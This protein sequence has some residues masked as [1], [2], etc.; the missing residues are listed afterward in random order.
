M[1]PARNRLALNFVPGR[2]R[3]Q[4]P[5]EALLDRLPAEFLEKRVH[6]CPVHH[7]GYGPDRAGRIGLHV[8]LMT[9]CGDL[10]L[11]GSD[12]ETAFLVDPMTIVML[13]HLVSLVRGPPVSM[14]P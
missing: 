5:G 11:P 10:D 2:P 14:R 6:L 1:R 4:D 3:G 7:A 12:E 9:V 8:H 13:D